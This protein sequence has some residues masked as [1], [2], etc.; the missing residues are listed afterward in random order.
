MDS[1]KEKILGRI[2]NCINLAQSTSSQGESLNAMNMARKLMVLHAIDMSEVEQ[3]DPSNMG[4]IEIAV[5]NRI[6]KRWLAGALSQFLGLYG[7]YNKSNGSLMIFGDKTILDPFEWCWGLATDEIDRAV[8][9]VRGSKDNYR[10]QMVLG[11]KSQLS[12]VQATE[13][14][15]ITALVVQAGDRAK[16]FALS[17]INVSVGKSR[18]TTVYR[19][20]QAYSQG[21]E[22]GSRL[23][24][25]DNL[26]GGE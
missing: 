6:W 19:D 24:N 11:I 17:Q 3:D 25:K 4:K 15:E 1:Q 26:L 12:T 16:E 10:K 8:Q 20:Q 5:G 2:R 21:Q 7:V 22:I 18:K 9:M 23:R 13:S 14:N